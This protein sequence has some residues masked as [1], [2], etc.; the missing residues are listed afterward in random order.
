MLTSSEVSPLAVL[1]LVVT[2]CGLVEGS[3]T[4]C[5]LDL[6]ADKIHVPENV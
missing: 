5:H 2:V 1:R 3:P 6:R 4:C